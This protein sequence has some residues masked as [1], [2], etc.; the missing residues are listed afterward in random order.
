VTKRENTPPPPT[1]PRRSRAPL[2]VGTAALL[3]A[4]ALAW[5]F[6]PSPGSRADG[7]IVLISID[8]LR[9]DRLPAYGY[10]ATKTP[11]I[12]RLVQDGV[13]LERAYSH[14]PQTLPSHTSLFSGQLPFEHGVRDNIGFTVKPG[15]RLLQHALKERGY[16]TGGFVSAYVLRE[17]TGF[18]QGFDH[19]DDELP[20]A[21]PTLPLG[22]VQRPGP[23]TVAAASRWIDGRASAK[24]F[25]FVHIYEPHRPYAPP[26][27][28]NSGNAYDGEVDYS[29]TIIGRL[30]DHLR[31]RGLYDSATIALFSDHGEGLGDH[32]EDEH[33]IFLY[34]ET[35]QVPLVVKL[36]GG[37]GGNR[38]VAT[39]V[40]LIDLYSTV[41]DVTGDVPPGQRGRSLMPL[42]ENTGGIAEAG[43]YSESLTP[44]YHFGWS[45]LYALT[46]ER[47]RL[48]RAPKDEL[49]DV[50]QDPGELSSIAADRSQVRD[51]MRRALDRMIAD[52]P[53]AAPSAVSEQDRQKLAALGY[54]GTQTGPAPGADRAG[55]PDPK[56]KI[57]VLKQYKHATDLAGARK[58]DEAA[59]VMRD[60]L[61]TDP[62][63]TDVWIQLAGMYER[64]GRTRDAV[65]AYKEGIRSDP[66]S[67]SSLTGAAAGLLRLGSLDEA[68]AHAELAV[69]VAPATAHELLARIAIERGDAVAARREAALAREADPTLPTPQI[70]EGVLLHK[71]G[72]FAAAL[73]H[74][75]Q[76]REAVA[77]R[78][79][80]LPDLDYYIADCLARLERYAEAEKY[81]AAELA[82]FPNNLR[83]RAGQAMLFRATGRDRESEA[84]I[85][86]MIRSSP[87]PQAYD[88][89][90]QLWTMFGE[91]GR[92]AGVRAKARRTPER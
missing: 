12:D 50:T 49:F 60:L 6:W 54:V 66:Q 88:L 18:S 32:G 10:A 8:T 75:L 11:H 92:A 7:P 64:L 62:Q 43:I 13:L 83:A 38:R 17:Q 86:D 56:D 40:Q 26:A 59:A 35:I 39:P 47:Y 67:A 22:Q 82:I 71:Q 77:G 9:A 65:D 27:P 58:F 87:T 42:L 63:M 61:R 78:T 16:T 14:A 85:E 68:R 81:F 21:S 41:L 90:A 36:P 29:D 74:F 53:I 84:A 34:R 80:K 91:P 2:V 30:L 3:I 55:L 24:F 31:E 46:D 37:R 1:Q 57:S 51:A 23:D 15:Q 33:G 48:I 52:V 28:F 69:G 4:G 19:Y 45:E 76:A 73:P 79:I 72:Q 5:F 44:R 25:L 89:A 70:V 20:P